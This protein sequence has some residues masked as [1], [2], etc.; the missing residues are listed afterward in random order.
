M[1]NFKA[2][3]GCYG[4][5]TSPSVWNPNPLIDVGEPLWCKDGLTDW[6]GNITDAPLVECMANI[7]VVRDTLEENPKDDKEGK[8]CTSLARVLNQMTYEYEIQNG[9]NGEG[10]WNTCTRTTPTTTPKPP[11]TPPE[12]TTP[13]PTTT[14]ADT[15]TATEIGDNR[16]CSVSHGLPQDADLLFDDL[17]K[18]V[19]EDYTSEANATINLAIIKLQI[20]STYDRWT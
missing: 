5:P 11:T 9:E 10:N 14:V 15:T 8:L 20:W 16:P 13:R 12:P 3:K 7:L 2:N 1:Y 18:L 6:R 4:Q 19:E 17:K